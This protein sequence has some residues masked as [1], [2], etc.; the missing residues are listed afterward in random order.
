[1]NR[2]IELFQDVDR[3]FHLKIRLPKIKILPENVR[4]FFCSAESAEVDYFACPGK[5]LRRT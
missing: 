3:F 2:H 1:M 4:I 5:K